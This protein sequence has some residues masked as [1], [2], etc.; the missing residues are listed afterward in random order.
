MHLLT[1]ID[2]T[3][4]WPEAFPIADTTADT[5]IDVFTAGW[6]ARFGTPDYIK[7]DKGT[8]FTSVTWSDFC[9]QIGAQHIST[10]AL[11]PQSNGIV[12]R[13]HRQLK[14]ALCARGCCE[15]W[16]E[17]LPWVLL[18]LRAA[19]KEAANVSAA[20]AVYGIQL[21]RFLFCPA[22]GQALLQASF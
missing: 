5:C 2:R 20:E 8:Q 16:L 18:G 15:R 4:R 17:H 19:P 13:W 7:T 6:I 12:E 21:F 14:E 3:T 11:H 10:S 1:V 22:G 9:Q